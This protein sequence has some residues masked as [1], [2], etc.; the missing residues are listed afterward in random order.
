MTNAV[1]AYLVS[2]KIWGNQ[3]ASGFNFLKVSHTK[4]RLQHAVITPKSPQKPL[5]I[6]KQRKCMSQGPS[7][8]PFPD[9]IRS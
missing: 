2:S 3:A 7:Q 8:T 1:H 4:I 6:W 5:I 9:S